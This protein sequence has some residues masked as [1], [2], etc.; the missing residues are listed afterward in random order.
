MIAVMIT[1]MIT[2]FGTKI[3]GGAT[4]NQQYEKS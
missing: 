4:I 1:N 3:A 2:F